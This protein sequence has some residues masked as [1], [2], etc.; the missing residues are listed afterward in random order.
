MLDY[1]ISWLMLDYGWSSSENN[2]NNLQRA[3]GPQ[4]NMALYG[5]D[6]SSDANKANSPKH[7][8]HG[9]KERLYQTLR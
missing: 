1:G 2:D 5:I 3:G 8:Q 9:S 4:Q 6:K 7:R